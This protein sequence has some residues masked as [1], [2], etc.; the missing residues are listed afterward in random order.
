M[1]LEI[2]N[3]SGSIPFKLKN[4]AR[5]KTNTAC[6]HSSYSDL[7]ALIGLW[8][9]YKRGW[10]WRSCQENRFT[11]GKQAH[12]S[13]TYEQISRYKRKLSTSILIIGMDKPKRIGL[14]KFKLY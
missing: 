4:H 2:D 7:K 3:G 10:G 13:N 14:A 11:L 6:V 12:I 8:V 5:V 1:R 9:L